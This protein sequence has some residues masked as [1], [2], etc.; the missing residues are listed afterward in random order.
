M[1]KIAIILFSLLLSAASQ[2]AV[3]R[4]AS[5]SVAWDDNTTTKALSIDGTGANALLVFVGWRN[6]ASSTLTAHTYNGEAMTRVGTLFTSASPAQ[7]IDVF[8]LADPAT[9]ANDVSITSSVALGFSGN[10]AAIVAHAVSGADIAGLITDDATDEAGSPFT[11]MGGSL[12][13]VVGDLCFDFAMIMSTSATD[14]APDAGQTSHAT[15]ASGTTAYVG[16]SSET[17]A[18]LVSMGWTYGPEATYN[19]SWRG[20]CVA[21]GATSTSGLLLRRRRN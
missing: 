20:I 16:S 5:A 2:A 4:L 21:A 19:A 18:A 1:R 9:G 11:S 7:S 12:D 14:L 3:T 10:D 15:V 17:G 8:V 13:A 6:T